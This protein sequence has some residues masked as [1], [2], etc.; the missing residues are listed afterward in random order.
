MSMSVREVLYRQLEPSA[1]EAGLSFTNRCIACLIIFATLVAVFETEVTVRSLFPGFFLY[2]EIF[3]IALFSVEY[4]ARLIAAGEQEKYAGFAGRIRYLFSKWSIIDL[5]AI[6]PFILTLGG[7]N[8]VVVRLLKFLRLVRILRLGPFGAA[9]SIMGEA[10]S[11]RK[12]ELLLSLVV[13]GFLL[14]FSASFIYVAEAAAQPEEF[15]SIPR[16]LWW[17]VAT[18]TTVGY[19]DVT[20]VTVM[21]RIFA[22]F[23][24]AA[25]IGLVA[26]PTGVLAAAFSDAFQDR[27]NKME[28][29][30]DSDRRF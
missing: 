27:R 22:G 19:G 18:L 26:M 23:A 12:Y 11:R 5:I 1:R 13:A 16:S 9:W 14:V 20:P 29:K 30:G 7:V 2:A 17:A 25:G 8:L 15:G 3:F 4:I 21:G 28:A 6:L 24:A 10:I